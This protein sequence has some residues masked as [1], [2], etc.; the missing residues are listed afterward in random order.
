M[1]KGDCGVRWEREGEQETV[2]LCIGQD[3]GEI[4]LAPGCPVPGISAEPG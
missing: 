4:A 3:S 2:G 1:K